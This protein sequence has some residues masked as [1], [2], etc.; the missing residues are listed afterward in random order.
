MKNKNNKK[1]LWIIVFI[2]IV[3]LFLFKNYD[4]EPNE[5]KKLAVSLGLK[6]VK[7]CTSSSSS[8]SYYRNYI[9]KCSNFDNLSYDEMINIHDEMMDYSYN[10][11]IQQYIC[12]DNKYECDEYLRIVR[13]NS[14]DVYSDY[15]NSTAYKDLLAEQ[16]AEER[17]KTLYANR[18]PTVGMREEYLRYTILGEPDSIEKC[19][20]FDI[21]K[22]RSKCKTYK[23]EKTS[24]HGWYNITVEYRMHKS[25][26]FDDYEDLPIFN[27]YVSNITYTDESG[28]I[29]S[30]SYVDTY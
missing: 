9:I 30:K 10:V 7:V 16:E 28:T 3:V 13:L 23:W 26:Q 25:H 11:K 15:E 17:K 29:Q 20:D 6:D 18:Y 2:F 24:K 22:A 5:I 14:K 27:G 1:W 21:L 12:N 8:T 4:P 19:R